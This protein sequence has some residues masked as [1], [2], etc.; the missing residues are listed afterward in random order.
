MTTT[1]VLPQQQNVTFTLPDRAAAHDEEGLLGLV[2]LVRDEQH[3]R[4][5]VAQLR[6]HEALPAAGQRQAQE[7]T[8]T[9]A[10]HG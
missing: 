8:M 9:D 7:T 10:H 2:H 1:Y 5:R 4:A 6:H 3:G